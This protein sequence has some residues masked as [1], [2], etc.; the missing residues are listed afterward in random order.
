MSTQHAL[1]AGLAQMNLCIQA[2]DNREPFWSLEAY[3][4]LQLK[5]G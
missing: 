3:A 2:Q 1:Q 4:F 5:A